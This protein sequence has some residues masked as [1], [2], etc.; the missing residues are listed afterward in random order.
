M[1]NPPPSLQPCRNYDQQ[2]TQ[3]ARAAI[4]MAERSPATPRQDQGRVWQPEAEVSQIQ[5]LNAMTAI[6]Q[7]SRSHFAKIYNKTCQEI[8]AA[9]NGRL[10]DDNACSL[11]WRV[12]ELS[13]KLTSTTAELA[14]RKDQLRLSQEALAFAQAA[15][16]QPRGPMPKSFADK[17]G[18]AFEACG[19]RTDANPFKPDKP[20]PLTGQPSP[21]QPHAT[22]VIHCDS[23]N[24][25]K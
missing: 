22:I 20:N 5:T 4:A 19:V 25:Q 16:L 3:D 6:Q 1:P 18:E 2:I 7:K 24:L 17:L 8:E 15:K 23:V 10:P 9:I 13:G 21:L 14:L 12:H 11:A